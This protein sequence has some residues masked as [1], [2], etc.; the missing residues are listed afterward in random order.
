MIHGVTYSRVLPITEGAAID[1]LNTL[2]RGSALYPHYGTLASHSHMCGPGISTKP[3]YCHDT[4]PATPTN[5]AYGFSPGWPMPTKGLTATVV[6]KQKWS[7]T[8]TKV[9]KQ[10][11]HTRLMPSY[12]AKVAPV[13]NLPSLEAPAR[14]MAIASH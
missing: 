3:S 7:Q 12:P 14:G 4:H 6:A 8:G 5:T 1:S 10:L 13:H 9:R 2:C 11:G